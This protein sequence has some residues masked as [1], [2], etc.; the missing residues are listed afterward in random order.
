MAQ[1]I[2]RRFLTAEAQVRSHGSP[3]GTCGGQCGT[4]TGFAP[5]PSIFT[6]Q[7]HSI[8]SQYSLMYHLRDGQRAR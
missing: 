8:A 5:R 3:Y 4:G 6:C 7:Y 1:A 2:N